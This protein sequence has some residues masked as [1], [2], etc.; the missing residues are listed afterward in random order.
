M[1][2]NAA[3]GQREEDLHDITTAAAAAEIEILD[4]VDDTKENNSGQRGTQ[5]YY[6]QQQQPP[7]RTPE[8]SQA[9]EVP[10]PPVDI[11][12]AP[13]GKQWTLYFSV[14]GARAE[15]VSV[16][17]D[18]E[19]FAVVV[20][21]IIDRWPSPAR[22]D[23]EEGERLVTIVS[24]RTKAGA[25]ERAVKIPRLSAATNFGGVTNDEA[26][27]MEGRVVEWKMQDGLLI[28]IVVVRRGVGGD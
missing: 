15:T 13:S 10:F 19:R 6:S 14:A 12:A 8:R 2:Q 4:K 11:L 7:I 27:E 5:Y 25:F 3:P 9:V 17:W 1:S 20:R 26:E 16:Q 18:S 24:E 21:G 23:E 28:V 22:G